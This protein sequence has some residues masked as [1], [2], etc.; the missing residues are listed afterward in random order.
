MRFVLDEV[1]ITPL[2]V[3]PICNLAKDCI[4]PYQLQDFITLAL[5][6][7]AIVI[8]IL[9]VWGNTPVVEFSTETRGCVRVIGGE[10]PSCEN[11]PER[12]DVVWV[13]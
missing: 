8:G 2:N 1:Y 13:K 5:A 7:I 3:D 4:M 10:H 9:Y 6:T 12:Y 11:L